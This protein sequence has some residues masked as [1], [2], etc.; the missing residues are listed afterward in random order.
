[1]LVFKLLSANYNDLAVTR[2]LKC[3]KPINLKEKDK[4]KRKITSL[5]LSLPEF[6]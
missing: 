3:E 4:W 1:M 2:K 6:I 5:I